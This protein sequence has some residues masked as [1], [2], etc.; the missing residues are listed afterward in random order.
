[1]GYT[2]N[3]ALRLTGATSSLSDSNHPGT[4]Y[5]SPHYNGAGSLLSA[6]IGNTGSSVSETRTYDGRLRLTN[7]ADG[8]LYT[9]TIPTNGYA[10]DSD[11]LLANDSVNGNWAYGY[12]AFN[13]L[14]SA[15]ATGQSYTYDYDRFGNR[16]HQNGPHSS[17]LSFNGSNNRMDTYSYDAVGDL[18]NDGTTAYT[19]D[20]ESRIISA[21]NST[22]GTSTYLYDADGRRIRKTT[23]AGGTVDFLYDLGGHEIS[24]VTSAGSWNRGEI[25][26]GGRHLGTYSGGTGGTTYFTFADHL[27]TERARST[28]TGAAYETCA[29]WPFGD[30]LT[31][32]GSSDP[33]PMHLTGKERDG[34]S[35]LDEFG[36]RYY[37]SQY[38]R[39]MTPDWASGASPVPYADFSNPQT[40]NLYSYV[41]NNPTTLTDPNGHCWS[42]VQSFCNAFQRVFYFTFTDYGFKNHAQVGQIQE[43]Q[44]QWLTNYNARRVNNDGVATPVDWSKQS[45]GYVHKACDE[46][47]NQVS[48]THQMSLNLPLPPG[49]TAPEFGQDVMKWGTGDD[50]ARAR[51]QTLT[52]EELEERGVTKEMAEGWRDLYQRVK[53]H[54][55]GNPSAQGRAELMQKAVDLLGGK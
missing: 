24:Q 35:G 11:I 40:L 4:L 8:A 26:A 27:G 9:L 5:S 31:C 10:P 1:V 52:R 46:L 21:T 19:Y 36:A 17:S 54:N 6:Q 41:K 30:W 22:S 13:R 23:T 20:S 32:S 25:Y 53:L 45:G 44:R 55:P 37:S 47:Q 14:T 12:D 15:G 39:F 3:R 50:A 42:W 16:W 29:S 38:G 28:S 7:I 43:Q 51:M 18:L 34:E 49:M 33:S 2:V 48:E